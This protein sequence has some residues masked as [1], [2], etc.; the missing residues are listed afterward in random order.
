[1]RVHVLIYIFFPLLQFTYKAD[2]V[3]LTFLQLLSTD[4]TQN[5]TYHCRN[6]VAYYSNAEDSLNQAAKFLTS[7]D[8]EL[9]AE[10]PKF[11][12]EV[13][14][15]E[16]QVSVNVMCIVFGVIKYRLPCFNITQLNPK[17]KTTHGQ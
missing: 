16:C 11:R 2:R 6:S 5:V 10:S 17:I 15:D 1:M 7:N 13:T 14:L 9:Q 8:L 4:A 3:Q 12:Y